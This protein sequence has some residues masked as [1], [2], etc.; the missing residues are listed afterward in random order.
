MI[1]FGWIDYSLVA[2]AF[3]PPDNLWLLDRL[4]YPAIRGIMFFLGAAEVL[5]GFALWGGG[6]LIFWGEVHTPLHTMEMD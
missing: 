3:Q 2:F 1:Q 6:R 4:N 5:G